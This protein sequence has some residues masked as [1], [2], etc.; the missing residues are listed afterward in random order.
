MLVEEI[1][2]ETARRILKNELKSLKNVVWVLALQA[3]AEFAA[4]LKRILDAYR[5]LHSSTHPVVMR[6]LHQTRPS[7][8]GLL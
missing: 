3:S 7:K 2:Q 1:L 6:Y 5:R 4:H 8:V